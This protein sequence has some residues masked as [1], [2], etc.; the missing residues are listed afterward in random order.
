[1]NKNSY[2]KKAVFVYDLNKKFIEKYEGVTEAERIFKINHSTIKKYAKVSGKYKGYIF[3]YK[4][5]ELED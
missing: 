1:M 2:I 3:S 5:L 4:R